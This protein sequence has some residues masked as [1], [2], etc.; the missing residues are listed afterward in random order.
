MAGSAVDLIEFFF[1]K[2]LNPVNARTA[3]PCGSGMAGFKIH[4]L[5]VSMN[6]QSSWRT[7]ESERVISFH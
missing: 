1:L 6:K 4:M 7:G 2:V 5:S 3:L